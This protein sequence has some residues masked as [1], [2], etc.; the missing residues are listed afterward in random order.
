[1][2]QSFP[3][4][5]VSPGSLFL[6]LLIAGTVHKPPSLDCIPYPEN[7][8]YGSTLRRAQ[9]GRKNCGL[10]LLQPFERQRGCRREPPVAR[11]GGVVYG[12]CDEVCH[13]RVNIAPWVGGG[14]G[15]CD[16]SARTKCGSSMK[17]RR[18]GH[19]T[20]FMCLYV[21]CGCCNR[22]KG[23]EDADESRPLH[24]TEV[25]YIVEAHALPTHLRLRYR[26]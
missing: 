5:V 1:L 2:G 15:L 26:A 17:R 3:F 8:P 13:A 16:C 11:Y 20:R 12:S 4:P 6:K 22:S 23:K 14:V 24:G 7:I 9:R 21:G 10:W 25:S 19:R 18:T